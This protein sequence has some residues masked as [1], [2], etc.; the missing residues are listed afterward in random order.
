M[1]VGIIFD[2]DGTAAN[3]VPW[4]HQQLQHVL[5]TQFGIRSDTDL[6]K[7]KMQQCLAK[8]PSDTSNARKYLLKAWYHVGRSFGLGI[9]RS[10]WLVYKTGRHVLET[11]E[12]PSMTEGLPEL[13]EWCHQQGTRCAMVSLSSERRVT[14]FLEH[15]G[16]KDFFD[17]VLTKKYV[18]KNKIK[19]FTYVIRKWKADVSSVI[20]VGDLPG[21]AIAA[22]K[23]GLVPYLI[24]T[25]FA[26]REQLIQSQQA[27]VVRN[28][29]ELLGILKE[30]I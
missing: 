20:A 4:F 29:K 27:P 14:R 22:R 25:G 28:F 1:L 8:M 2:Y 7:S 19:A 11:K 18:G 21:D 15:H 5:A 16:I 24:S 23:V 3:T 9:L 30:K 12:M 26:S 6:I 13:P 17:V 10:C